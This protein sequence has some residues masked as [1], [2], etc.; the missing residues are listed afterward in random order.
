MAADLARLMGEW[1]NGDLTA[2][3][4]GARVV[5]TGSATRFGRGPLD[6]GLRGDGGRIDRR[7]L[8]PLALY[9][10]PPVRRSP[11]RRTRN[12]SRPHSRGTA[13]ARACRRAS[14][15]LKRVD[16][17]WDRLQ[18]SWFSE[19]VERIGQESLRIFLIEADPAD[20][21]GAAGERIDGDDRPV[22]S[23]IASRDIEMRR[24]AGERGR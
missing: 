20:R 19:L 11:G 14:F 1:L 24:H 13:Q 23:R 6:R 21:Q 15:F 7:A 3:R 17:N 10:E 22:Q 2:R 4:R 8:G 12:R 16:F 9:R 5:R 18:S